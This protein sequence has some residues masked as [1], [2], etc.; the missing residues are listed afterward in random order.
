MT[1]APVAHQQGRFGR[2][3]MLVVRLLYSVVNGHSPTRALPVPGA[4]PIYGAV[5]AIAYLV[6]TVALKKKGN[7]ATLSGNVGT[8]RARFHWAE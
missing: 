3:V 6:V 7:T 1:I 5:L 2:M 8:S 4:T